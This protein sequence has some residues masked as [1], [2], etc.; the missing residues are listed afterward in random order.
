VVVCARAA[1]CRADKTPKLAAAAIQQLWG[2]EW[3]TQV[4]VQQPADGT[5]KFSGFFGAYDWS[6]VDAMG[7]V[8]RGVVHFGRGRRRRAAV[9]SSS[10]AG[11]RQQGTWS[12][13]PQ[14]DAV[15]WLK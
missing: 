1:A 11:P 10:R 7:T 6:F 8:Q 9:L 13:G 2:S 12:E 4:A 3:T 15:R 5:V 14:Q